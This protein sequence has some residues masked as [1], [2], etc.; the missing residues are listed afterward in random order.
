MFSYLSEPTKPLF[1]KNGR[2]LLFL[3]YFYSQKIVEVVKYYYV[4]SSRDRKVSWENARKH[5]D[6][7][8][9]SLALPRNA[10]ENGKLLALMYD[11]VKL[12]YK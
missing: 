11:K 12:S 4:R 9:M 10:E 7:I 1:C 6:D 8:Q 3:V 2:Y 5:C